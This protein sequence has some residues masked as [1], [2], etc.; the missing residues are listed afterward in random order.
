MAESDYTNDPKVRIEMTHPV[1][2]DQEDLDRLANGEAVQVPV[3]LSS[4][5]VIT[6]DWDSEIGIN[7]AGSE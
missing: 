1:Q 6:A 2:L 3:T 4:A 7:E 5:V